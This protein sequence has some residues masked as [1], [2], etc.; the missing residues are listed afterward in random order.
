MSI[1]VLIIPVL[2]RYDLL[3]QTLKSIDHPIDNIVII[4]NGK[5]KFYSTGIKNVQIFDMP[6]NQGIAGSWNLG[7]KFYP[8][9]DYWLFG[10]ADTKYLPGSL[11]KFEEFSGPDYFINSTAA[12]SSFSLGKN[13]VEKVGLFDEYIY[14]AY[15]EDNDYNDRMIL[16]G[17]EKNILS[18]GIEVDDNGGSQ[19]IKSDEVLMKKNHKTFESNK[20]YYLNKFNTKDYTCLGWD[21]KKRKENEWLD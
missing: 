9:S 14:P 5:N 19:T 13:I 12:Y 11:K 4:N 6:S 8:H 18:P 3:D 2:N 16:A 21:L 10:S 7:I 17:F 15:F 20:I 1:P